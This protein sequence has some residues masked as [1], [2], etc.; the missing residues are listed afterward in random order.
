MP[1][2]PPPVAEQTR[3]DPQRAA[4]VLIEF[5][6]EWVSE[7]GRLRFLIEDQ[8]QFDAAVQGG[9]EALQIARQAGLP[10]FHV[11]L[12]FTEGYPEFRPAA[13]GLRGAIPNAQT[14]LASTGGA[15][16]HPDFQ[17]L[18]HEIVIRGRNG[19]S[20]FAGSDLHEQLQR[21]GIETLYLAGFAMHVC[22]ESTLREAHDRGYAAIL[23][24]DASAAFN[25]AQRK[26]VLNHIVHHFG[27][28]I[29]GSE[30]QTR[31]MRRSAGAHGSDAAGGGSHSA[32]SDG[33]HLSPAS[34]L[35]MNDAA[36]M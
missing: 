18:D 10:V 9:R 3:P 14:W 12:R 19:A 13:H 36:E 30:F 29:D 24:E 21:E 5:Q 7:E 8:A 20:G 32:E 6:N 11:G 17:P 22:V 27:E 16:F 28:S 34:P 15:A 26:Y 35:R 1:P 2:V 4:L 25:A 23:L 33:C 31:V